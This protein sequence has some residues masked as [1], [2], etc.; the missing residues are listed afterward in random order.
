[1]TI[2]VP[3]PSLVLL[4]GASGSG[5]S[6]FARKHFLPT[7]IVS[8]EYCRA[9]VSENEDD[10]TATGLAFELV[11][12]IARKRLE[13]GK[14]TVID[15]TNVQSEARRSLIR[16]AREYYIQ[17]IGIVLNLPERLCHERNRSR[18][19]RQFD[20]HVVR[21]QTA[22]IRQSLHGLGREGFDDV[23]VLES[24]D[25]VAAATIE[26]A[27]LPVDKRELLGP[28]DIIGDVHGCYDELEVLLR[29]LGYDVVVDQGHPIGAS[30]PAGR[31]AVFLGDLVDR[32]PRVADVLRLAM[33]MSHAGSA[34]VLLGNHENKLLRK[35][36]GRNVQVGRG[37]AQ[38]L[39]QLQA[40]PPGFTR[41][42]ETFL[43]NCVG[44]L[45]LD[46]GKLVVAHAGSTARMHGR[47]DRRARDFSLYGE[48]TG[49]TDEYSHPV[50][51]NWAA[52]YS[53]FA[54]VVYGHT[55]V[56]T[57]EWQNNTICV[58]TGCV[59]GGALTALRYPERALV[60]APA[61]RVYYA[62]SQPDAGSSQTATAAPLLDHSNRLRPRI[63]SHRP[64]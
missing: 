19:N 33:A 35:L 63:R 24:A 11:H 6:S 50:R 43:S 8:S 9:L 25:E 40:R 14:L 13:L 36:R 34:L 58:D 61:A 12:F 46:R 3:T 49:E 53:G 56:P 31:Q 10:Q 18:P 38:T 32:G 57:A 20:P 22:A 42:I 51:F 44:Q 27:A 30:H 52:E 7:E 29:Q 28:F 2:T 5:K 37:L 64:D 26:R 54:T 55:P 15:G 59:F 21:R 41:E 1:M 16:L 23:H 48:S 17:V 47:F 4:I 45:V 39:E 60:S 62:P